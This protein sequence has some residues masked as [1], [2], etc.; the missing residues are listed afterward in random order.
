MSELTETFQIIGVA[1]TAIAAVITI[2][3][4]GPIRSEYKSDEK[5][6]KSLKSWIRLF[7]LIALLGWLVVPWICYGVYK[8][9]KLSTNQIEY[10]ERPP[11]VIPK[12]PETIDLNKV[13]KDSK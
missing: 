11:T 8:V 12:K 13:E 4:W 10:C 6:Y 3:I 2:L 1:V 7:A 9:A 5:T